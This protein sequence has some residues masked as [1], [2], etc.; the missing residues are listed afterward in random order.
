MISDEADGTTDTCACRFW[1]VSWT[2]TRKPFQS[3]VALA[4]SSPTFFGAYLWRY[5]MI[6]IAHDNKEVHIPNREDRLLVQAQRKHQ[7]HHR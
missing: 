6:S 4:M 7:L 5:V 3:P 2:V 1:M